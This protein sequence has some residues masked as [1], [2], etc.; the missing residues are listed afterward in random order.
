VRYLEAQN[1]KLAD[2]LGKL[3]DKWGKETKAIK[4]QFQADL[5]EARRNLDDA[6]KDKA[7]LEIR[8]AS[9]DEQI[10]ELNLL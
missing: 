3:R 6:E 7:R 9:L 2:D 5:D 4:A 1:K 10:D 8:A